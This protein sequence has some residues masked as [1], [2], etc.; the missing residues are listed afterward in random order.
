MSATDAP[1]PSDV[2]GPADWLVDLRRDLHRHPEPAWRE[3]YTTSRIIYAIEALEIDDL[4]LFVGPDALDLDARS[5]VPEADELTPWREQAREEGVPEDRLETLDGGQTGL[6]ARLD[7]G[8]GPHVALRVDI[9][10]LPVTESDADD[11]VPAAEGFRSENDGAMHACGHDGHATIGIGTLA[12][13]AESDFQGSFTVCFQPA[14]EII[15]GG[16]A[17]AESGHLDGVDELVA[18]HLGLDHPTGE[19]VAGMEDFLAVRQLRARFE[20]ETAHAGAHPE[21][22]R[23]AIQAMAAAVQNLYAIPRHDGGA[24]RVN[25]GRIEGGTASNVVPEEAVI[26]GEVRGE[27]TELKDFM[28]DHADRVLEGAATMHDCSVDVVTTGEAPSAES[29]P[30]LRGLVGEMA[31]ETHGVDSVL[32]RAPLGGSEDATFLMRRVQAQ[33]GRATFVCIGTD[34]PGGHHTGT[35]D[36]DEASIA[37]GVELLSDV[38]LRLGSA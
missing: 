22:G 29:D 36:V 23:N 16:R 6:V 19:I 4:S 27:S 17:I 24:T 26:E 38:V 1:D 7:R 28:S 3:F 5:G 35:F 15:G 14:E 2:D 30:D 18:I 21:A 9:D 12:A 10:G 32:D 13:V 34:H 31:G 8:D 33:G 20:G 25:A 11:H 37:I